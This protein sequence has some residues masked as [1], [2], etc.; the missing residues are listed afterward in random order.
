MYIRIAKLEVDRSRDL[1]EELVKDLERAGYL[2]VESENGFN[3]G[4]YD[5][6]IVKKG[7][8]YQKLLREEGDDE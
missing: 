8:D 7:D 3:M 2:V 6:A 4:Y 5:I 1:D